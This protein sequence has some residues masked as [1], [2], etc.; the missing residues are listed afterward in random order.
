M[1]L[2]IFNGM[3]ESAQSDM[4]EVTSVVDIAIMNGSTGLRN[5]KV[6]ITI[7]TGDSISPM[8]N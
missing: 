7:I 8:M 4:K 5:N 3:D 1:V 2:K 6:L